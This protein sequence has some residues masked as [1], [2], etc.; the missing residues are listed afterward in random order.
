MVNLEGSAVAKDDACS[1][2]SAF[3]GKE[4]RVTSVRFFAQDNVINIISKTH[5]G[6]AQCNINNNSIVFPNFRKY[7][8]SRS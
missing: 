1:T 5:L 7:G 6:L 4:K 8:V 2:V 3:D